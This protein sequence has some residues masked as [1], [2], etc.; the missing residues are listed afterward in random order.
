MRTQLLTVSVCV[1]IINMKYRNSLKLYFSLLAPNIQS[2]QCIDT[3]HHLIHDYIYTSVLHIVL[4]ML[5]FLSVFKKLDI[6]YLKI[7]LAVPIQFIYYIYRS[8]I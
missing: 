6:I 1:F 5:Q 7:N 2:F 8:I 4:L 3:C